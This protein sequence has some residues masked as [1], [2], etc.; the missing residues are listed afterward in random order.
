M[1]LEDF[2]KWLYRTE[3]KGVFPESSVIRS[4]DLYF[5]LDNAY[6]TEW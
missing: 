4:R 5:K 6:I 2:C 1:K 3:R